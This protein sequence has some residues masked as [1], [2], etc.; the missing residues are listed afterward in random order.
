MRP[1]GLGALAAD[2]T[3]PYNAEDEERVMSSTRDPLDR[4][5]EAVLDAVDV[6]GVCAF[7]R[8]LQQIERPT[9]F[10]SFAEAAAFLEERYEAAGL[11][12][13]RY[14]FTADG[15]TRYHGW[16]A[17]I[18]FVT[19]DAVCEIVEP[20]ALARILGDRRREPNT[21]VLGSGHTPPGGIVA[22]V[23][24]ATSAEAVARAPVAGKIVYCG[25]EQISPRL[26]AVAV[27]GGAA[28]VVSSFA[29]DDDPQSGFVKWHNV[30][31][32]QP[33]GWM[34]TKPA[35]D[36]NLPGL[37]IAPRMGRYLESCLA[38]GPVRLRVRVEGEYFTGELPAVVAVAAGRDPTT[39]LFTAHAFEPGLVDNAS[40]V[41]V[42]F[43][44]IQAARAAASRLGS[45]QLPRSIGAFHGQECYGVMAW[46]RYDAAR[47]AAV[48]SHLNV[49]QMGVAQAPL[50]VRPGLQ[51][52]MDFSPLLLR[53]IFGKL[54][55]R[56][57]SRR[58]VFENAFSINCT[59]L[60]DP[61]LGGVPTSQFEQD[62]PYWHSGRDRPEHVALD[63]DAM[64]FALSAAATWGLFQ[65]AADGEACAW[66]LDRAEESVRHASKEGA[67]RDTEL[68]FRQKARELAS[69]AALAG[70]REQGR[71][72]EGAKKVIE[73]A[74]CLVPHEERIEPA[75]GTRERER[76][77]RLFPL[78][79]LGGSAV[80]NLFTPAQLQ[81]LG[82]PKW[83][84][85][86]LVLK[87]WADGTRSVAEIARLASYELDEPVSLDDALAVFDA[88]A[89]Q[90]LVDMRA[91]PA[92]GEPRAESD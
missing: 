25:A 72:Q 89:R 82:S 75:G 62:N 18:G 32:T 5:I 47:V 68:Y 88:Y 65:A 74:R 35:A 2:R 4:M 54:A 1:A 92:S 90:G 87:S 30:W 11:T 64:T 3:D 49:D 86:Q 48:L 8:E 28:A 85:P 26:R 76:S 53:E 52:S 17:P 55:P 36:E 34:P 50:R 63:P 79:S 56:F 39:V 23:V 27:A 41:G 81:V 44:A 33:D 69:I 61:A 31:D 7:A 6:D 71:L 67:L 59:V 16:T 40:G 83:S 60:A 38:R 66:L 12:A 46:H 37:C 10:A 21:A 51:A 84:T 29:S 77:R 78:S 42:C 22:Q 13:K 45:P 20:A 91:K 80:A 14:G 19:R 43:G 24:L 73:E 15:E 9:D 57:G 58:V 70:G